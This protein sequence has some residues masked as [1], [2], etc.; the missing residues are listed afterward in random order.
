MNV[1][2]DA[3]HVD[4]SEVHSFPEI[5]IVVIA[6]LAPLK[7]VALSVSRSVINAALGIGRISHNH[8]QYDTTLIKLFV[9]YYFQRRSL[10]YIFIYFLRSFSKYFNFCRLLLLTVIPQR[11]VLPPRPTRFK[12]PIF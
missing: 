7:S 3:G 1:P 6:V 5:H 8:S 4:Y 10:V 11:R 12:T 9:S 2:D